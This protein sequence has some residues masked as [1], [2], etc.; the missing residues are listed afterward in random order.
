MA[1]RC[2]INTIEWMIF[3]TKEIMALKND[4]LTARKSVSGFS[5]SCTHFSFLWL[6]LL[7]PQSEWDLSL[8][9]R[10]WTCAPA[11]KQQSW[12]RD[13]QGSP[14]LTSLPSPQLT[15]TSSSRA[16]AGSVGS[17]VSQSDESSV[18][19]FGF[20][21]IPFHNRKSYLTNTIRSLDLSLL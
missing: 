20:V 8:L 16:D 1:G 14:P 5:S 11:V 18:G 6:F 4:I 17:D 12:P 10:D 21:F 2:P 15:C 13:C 19:F 9:T 3:P 7:V